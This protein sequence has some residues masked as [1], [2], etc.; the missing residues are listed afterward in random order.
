MV[1]QSSRYESRTNLFLRIRDP[2]YSSEYT[3]DI[4]IGWQSVHR[5]QGPIRRKEAAPSNTLSPMPS[6]AALSD[7]PLKSPVKPFIK[8]VNYTHL[9]PTRYTLELEGLKGA[10]SADNFKEVSQREDAKKNVK[11][12]LEERYQSGKNR[13]FFTPLRF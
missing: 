4:T 2:Q 6:S 10:V 3:I 12:V 9:M 5:H 1:A 7:T 13:W 8:I 11:K